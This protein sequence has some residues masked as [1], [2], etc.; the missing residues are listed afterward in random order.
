MPRILGK[1]KCLKRG[2]NSVE[3]NLMGWIAVG[4]F[5][6]FPWLA[7]IHTIFVRVLVYY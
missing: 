3:L 7:R 1:S 5:L 6:V 4:D 2:K